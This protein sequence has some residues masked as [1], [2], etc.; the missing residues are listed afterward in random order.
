MSKL[1]VYAGMATKIPQPVA[2]SASEIAGAIIP[3]DEPPPFPSCENVSKIETTVPKRPI[4]GEVDA[5]TLSHVSPLVA[6]FSAIL[7]HTFS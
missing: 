7:I 1:N 2:T 4:K 5:I 3:S 6:F